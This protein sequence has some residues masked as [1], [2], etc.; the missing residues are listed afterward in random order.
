VSQ[1]NLTALAVA[2]LI[3][4]GCAS[5]IPTASA[6][7]VPTP[8]PMRSTSAVLSASPTVFPPLAR[9]PVDLEVSASP[10]FAGDRL[11]L[12][13]TSS[14]GNAPAS[15][16]VGSASVDFGDGTIGTA[17]GSCTNRASLDHAYHQGGDYVPKVTEVSACNPDAVA[18]L[19]GT[20]ARVHVFPAAPAASANWPVCS[21]FQ[22]H[23]AGP[24]SGAGLGNVGVR[25]TLR[26]VGA[27]GCTLKGYPGLDLVGRDG[28]LLPT[29]V[30]RATTGA[31][32]FPG[33]APHT[34]ALAPGEVGSFMIGYTD[35]PFGPA[36]N[37]P[38]E[39]ACPPSVAVRVILPDTTQ[40]GTAK[41]PMGACGGIV[42]VSPIVP[43]ADGL[44]FS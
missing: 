4:C 37:E 21:T 39:I 23:L 20:S 41:V 13:V 7:T 5:P 8:S 3:A 16:L 15:L 6:P 44:Q 30:R 11:T 38:Y 2:A 42:D 33:I 29:H 34:V 24:W 19:S 26:N 28:A 40:F 31:Y 36:V 43:G 18:D 27:H 35:N 12:T 17:T 14:L 25:I 32:M 1:R 22:L 10:L 9:N